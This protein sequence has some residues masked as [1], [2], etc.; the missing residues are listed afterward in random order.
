MCATS[1]HSSTRYSSYIT[2]P[3][4]ICLSK[5]KI[6]NVWEFLKSDCFLPKPTKPG[7][8]GRKKEGRFFLAG[9]FEQTMWE[10]MIEEGTWREKESF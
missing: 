1:I 7:G 2:N 4:I 10:R 8:Q 5:E 9:K 6:I 3:S